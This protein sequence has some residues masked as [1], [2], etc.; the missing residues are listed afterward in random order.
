M[1]KNTKE[2]APSN[3]D[4]LRVPVTIVHYTLQRRPGLV[5]VFVLYPCNSIRDIALRGLKLDLMNK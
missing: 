5:W 3:V 4:R 2:A 1:G